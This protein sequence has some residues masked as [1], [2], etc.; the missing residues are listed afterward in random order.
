MFVPLKRNPITLEMRHVEIII[1]SSA[2]IVQL[3]KTKVITHFF[4]PCDSLR[5]EPF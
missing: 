3:A 1:S 5:G 4:D 2:R